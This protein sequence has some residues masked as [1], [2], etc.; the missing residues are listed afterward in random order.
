MK[1]LS[2]LFIVLLMGSAA[3]AQFTKG[4][5]MLDGQVSFYNQFSPASSAVPATNSSD[6]NLGF[7]ISHFTSPKTISGFGLGYGYSD[8]GN[9]GGSGIS[10][11]YNAFYNYTQLENWPI[12]STLVLE[13]LH[14]CN[15]VNETIQV[16]KPLR[17]QS[18][19][20]PPK[21]P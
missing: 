7:S 4:Q 5:K 11:S 16:R 15:I 8:N 12:V 3:N 1:N 10:N 2:F 6:L 17:L 20:L 13:E 19:L 18:N 9:I 21:L 14:P